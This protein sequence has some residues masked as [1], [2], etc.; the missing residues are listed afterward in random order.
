[1]QATWIEENLSRTKE[2]SVSELNVRHFNL[3]PKGV[4]DRAD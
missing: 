2:S 3:V 1:M 4:Y